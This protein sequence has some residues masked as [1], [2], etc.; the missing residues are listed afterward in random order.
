MISFNLDSPRAMPIYWSL[1]AA[2]N[3]RTRS[4]KS[5]ELCHAPSHSIPNEM[6]CVYVN[7]KPLSKSLGVE[8]AA[9]AYGGEK[10]KLIDTLI[11]PNK[12]MAIEIAKMRSPP[13][14]SMASERKDSFQMA[15]GIRSRSRARVKL[16]DG[17]N[18]RSSPPKAKITS[19]SPHPPTLSETS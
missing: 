6:P 1:I 11:G 16:V 10:K 12:R 3:E 4:K 9:G 5:K 18:S 13:P 8:V 7:I 14:S 17:V 19:S 15:F 2:A